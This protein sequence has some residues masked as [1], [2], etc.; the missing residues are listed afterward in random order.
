MPANFGL[1]SM[2]DLKTK[3]PLTTALGENPR[4][5]PRAGA[6]V[7]GFKVGRFSRQ[8]LDLTI[9]KGACQAPFS[10]ITFFLSLVVVSE[11]DLALE[12]L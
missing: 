10:K 12:R 3:K 4:V 1:A 11:C 5:R 2:W 6:C 8:Q 9:K 7:N